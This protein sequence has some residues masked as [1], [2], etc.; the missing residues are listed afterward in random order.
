MQV[1]RTTTWS[2]GNTLTASALNGEFNNLLNSPQ[3]VNA[4]IASSAAIATSKINATF[5]TG[6]IL[7]DTDTQTFSNKSTAQLNSPTNSDLSLVA[8]TANSKVVLT[9]VRR[10]GGSSTDFSI[11]GTTN[12]TEA[13]VAIQVG[14]TTITTGSVNTSVTFPVAFSEVPL[15]L[16]TYYDKAGNQILKSE[17]RTPTTSGFTI[18]TDGSGTVNGAVNW[19][20]L[21]KR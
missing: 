18:V 21:G 8:D 16:T 14:V 12:Y 3:I 20:A 5:P 19:I 17:I 9:T 6:V 15:V 11:D 1:T 4:D 13:S 10:Q 2:D 7:G